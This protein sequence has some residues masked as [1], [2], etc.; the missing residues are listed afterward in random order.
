MPRD[1]SVGHLLVGAGE[2]LG[3]TEENSALVL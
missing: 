2:V 1:V 3:L